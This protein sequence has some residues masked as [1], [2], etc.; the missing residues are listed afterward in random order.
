M[1][2]LLRHPLIYLVTLL[3]LFSQLVF[4]N[5]TAMTPKGNTPSTQISISTSV[6]TSSH[7]QEASDTSCQA[8]S[9][10][11]HEHE[12]NQQ[13]VSC[14]SNNTCQFNCEN[15]LYISLAD[16]LSIQTPWHFNQNLGHV[17]ATTPPYFQSIDASQAFKPPIS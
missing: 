17:I 16:T 8:C 3:T 5:P 12:K 15:C 7:H 4:A 13:T 9:N 14:Q 11:Q 10:C 1:H 6:I 2:T